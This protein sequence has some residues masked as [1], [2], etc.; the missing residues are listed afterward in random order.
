MQLALFGA[1][2]K[3]GK[4]LIEEGLKRG[5]D[6]TVFARPT[7]AFED[8]RVRVVRGEL[9]DQRVLDEAIG[10]AT[11]VLSAL[12]PTDPKH[13]AGTPLSKAFGDIATV[14]KRHSV[15]RL[16][17]V[18]TGTAADP[19]DQF[20][21]KIWAPAVLIKLL[22]PT[23]Y[24][25][26]V[27]IAQAIRDSNLDWTMARAAVLTDK[28]AT[29]DLNVGLYGTTKHSL[30]LSRADLAIFMYDQIVSREFSRA[31]PGISAR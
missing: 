28:S 10:G 15:Q 1:T 23:S 22:L 27:G 9:T 25:D 2:G 14:M 11:A 30:T 31:A 8:T 24:A 18:S 13:P 3:T 17:A 20:D 29:N 26:M 16:I 19:K 5:F 12:G 6:L 4:H 21:F 7:S